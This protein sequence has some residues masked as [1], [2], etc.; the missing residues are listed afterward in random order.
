M[1]NAMTYIANLGK[2]VTY[3]TVDRLKNMNP[4]LSDFADQNEELG[5]VLYESVKDFKGTTKKAAK[6]VS[7]SA[8][9]EFAKEYK[10]AFFEDIKSGKF[11]NK[12]REDSLNTRAAGDLLADDD[13]P[14]AN[15]DA[16]LNDNN[17]SSSKSSKSKWDNMSE[18]DRQTSKMMDT[19]GNKVTNGVAM[20]TARS[21]EFQVEAYRDGL[22]KQQKHAEFLTNKINAGLAG[23]NSTIAKLVEFNDKAFSVHIENSRNYYTEMTKL[24]RENNKLLQQLVQYNSN[25]YDKKEQQKAKSSTSRFSDITSGGMPSLKAYSKNVLNNLNAATGGILDMNNMFGEGSNIL[26]TMA[27][28]PFKFIPEM[29]AKKIIP[30][31]IEESVKG[32]NESLSGLFAGTMLKINEAKNDFNTPEALQKVLEIFGINMGVKSKSS[33]STNKYNKGPMPWDGEAKMALTR[34]IP[35][36]L[37]K[38]LAATTGASE[39][40]FDYETGKY[41]NIA[42]LNDQMDS[43]NR[44][45]SDAAAS[46][47]IEYMKKEIDKINFAGQ[48]ENYDRLIEDM[49]NMFETAYTNG[50]IISF[51]KKNPEKIDTYKLGITE[52]SAKILIPL[53]QNIVADDGLNKR[54]MMMSYNRK[55]L[56]NKDA[57]NRY[58]KNIEESST[59]LM[60]NLNNNIGYN[61]Y[62]N[63]MKYSN[64]DKRH[65]ITDVRDLTERQLR[66]NKNPNLI[67]NIYLVKDEYNKNIFWYL[68]RFAQEFATIR[69]NGITVN[70]ISGS[71]SSSPSSSI[72][73]LDENEAGISK[74]E[75]NR[76]IKAN[77]KARAN[78]EN[79]RIKLVGR[80]AAIGGSMYKSLSN[81]QYKDMRREEENFDR[82][83]NKKAENLKKRYE[84][85]PAGYM[86]ANDEFYAED[87]KKSM[88]R[89]SAY[90]KTDADF[91][92]YQ[93][94][95]KDYRE[96]Q[97]KYKNSL[98]GSIMEAESVDDRFKNIIMGVDEL[99]HKP[100]EFLAGI[101]GKV[102]KRLFNIVYGDEDDDKLSPKSF[103]GNLISRLT[104]TFANFTD[105]LKDDV[106]D[107]LKE[108]LFGNQEDS[109][110][111]KIKDFFKDENVK[112]FLKDAFGDKIDF[113]K[114][115]FK[116]KYG[117]FMNIVK[118]KEA[119]ADKISYAQD[120]INQAKSENAIREAKNEIGGALPPGATFKLDE[121]GMPIKNSKGGYEFIADP[122]QLANKANRI[123]NFTT[124]KHDKLKKQ[125]QNITDEVM[126]NHAKYGIDNKISTSKSDQAAI[127]RQIGAYEDALS[128][129]PSPE[130]A[131][132][133]RSQIKE[134]KGQLKEIKKTRNAKKIVRNTA[135]D[136]M[137][138]N[139]IKNGRMFGVYMKD[140]ISASKERAEGK[141]EYETEMNNIDS[142]LDYINKTIQETRQGLSK[143][144]KKAIKNNISK[145]EKQ[146]KEVN[147]KLSNP[148]L[149]EEEKISIKDSIKKLT[150]KVKYINKKLSNK[151]ISE[152]EAT[153]LNEELVKINKQIQENKAKLINPELKDNELE[154]LSNL[155][156]SLELSLKGY[157][158]K[159]NFKPTKTLLTN[160]EKS[161]LQNKIGGI[162]SAILSNKYRIQNEDL[163][164]AQIDVLKEAISQL[165]SEKNTYR[166]KL[167]K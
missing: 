103:M 112:Q 54:H 33:L 8:V 95:S 17:S 107:P 148:N 76:R 77:N 27:S 116:E 63:T 105:F 122:K 154:E 152:E 51:N 59:S 80:D 82:M 159:L 111:N 102:D 4:A 133:Y 52:D 147:T 164:D 20:A 55:I 15:L 38:I 66:N 21:A 45:Y 150:K 37:A 89:Y 81:R 114:D 14:F 130:E 1:A 106:L 100:A 46:E 127:E 28:S 109:L 162:D 79:E 35:D 108:T 120:I 138:A 5:R 24:T 129:S 9:G 2:S 16:L 47:I 61:E 84:E 149:S 161:S 25:M 69:T 7:E 11:Y 145:T 96:K 134:L 73:L 26:L 75:R 67:N 53:L 91:R 160:K 167:N 90:L 137:D 165:E 132:F 155:K 56:E 118:G 94:S 13:D 42:D 92:K 86:L 141:S 104:T 40:F 119:D 19:V 110:K 68:Q 140:A 34:V 44:K 163:S 43:L 151:D 88:S 65:I 142:R 143:R 121:N 146:L 99:S 23:M 85:A 50:Q 60:R 115:A 58:M 49:H 136:Q 6:Y 83:Q 125:Q 74:N 30:S 123:N 158:N 71:Y 36:Y 135:L 126:Q 87:L 48:K 131:K 72:E 93:A 113:V 64:N 57:Q 101:I 62:V 124:K 41:R 98:I 139:G 97:N 144:E 78:A 32:L 18:D 166:S 70:N 10:K 3:S 156:S 117:D 128:M 157:K 12:E 29:I 31:A 22:N 39:K 153:K